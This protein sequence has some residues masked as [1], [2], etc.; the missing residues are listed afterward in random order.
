MDKEEHKAIHVELHQKF[1]M[2]IADF[3]T[4][5]GSLLSRTTLMDLMVWSHEQTI[6]PTEE[7]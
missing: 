4:R 2:L 7:G 1:D 3:V 6:N 5:T